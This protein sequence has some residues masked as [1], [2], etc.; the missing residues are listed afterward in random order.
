MTRPPAL[1]DELL[2]RLR[3]RVTASGQRSY[4]PVDVFTGGEL[5][6]LPESTVD[7]VDAAVSTA[8]AAQQSWAKL[9]V[10]ERLAVFDRFHTLLLD[11]REQIMD[12]VQAETGKARRDAFEEFCEP[13]LVT[14]YYLRKASKLLRDKKKA[15]VLPFA[16]G[17]T[18]RRVP[19]GVVGIISPW[20]YPFALA[21]GDLIP[22]LIAGNAVVLKPDSQT[23]LSPLYGAELLAQAGLPAN[24]LQVVLGDG[25]TIGG[26][27]VDASDYVGFTGSTRTGTEI[28]KRAGARLIGCSL[29]LGG[30]NPLIVLDDADVPA[31]ARIAARGCFANAG[32]L[33]LAIERIY[34]HDAIVDGFAA[35]LVAEAEKLRLAA[36]YDYAA[37]LGS[38]TSA[39]A[40]ETVSAHVDDARAK[41]ATVLTGGHARPDLGPYF[42]TPTVLTDVTPEML[43][44]RAETFGPVVSLYSFG[45]DDDAV[46]QANDTGYGLNAG[47]IGRNVARATALARR[48]R[49]GTVNVN[50]TFASAFASTDAPMGGMGASGLGRR[51]GA[52]GLLRYTEA[53]TV[54]TQRV[55]IAAPAWLPHAGYTKVMATSLRLLRRARIR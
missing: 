22:A 44:H 55:S 41:G 40:I 2:D 9:D 29:E 36:G 43:C 3:A 1:T 10:A 42:Y 49:A 53:Q 18:E 26:A 13:A 25:P 37:D 33:C 20:N 47:V 16:V 7:D 8:A 46:E 12:L 54:A 27:V 51:H 39:R 48:L 50:D 19:K 28:A 35:A 30:K 15:G 21:L 14:A 11:H 24:L 5:A 31:A 23:A 38:L 4:A 32:Q 6:T 17:A 34:V 52:E 45:T